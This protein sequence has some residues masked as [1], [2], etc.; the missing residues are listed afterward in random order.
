MK[1][2]VIGIFLFILLTNSLSAQTMIDGLWDSYRF[3]K[4][5]EG[6]FPEY[7]LKMSEIKGTPYLDE[8]YKPG[9]IV[10]NEGTIYTDIPLRYNAYSDDLE[11]QKDK[12]AYKIEPK[13]IIKSAEFGGAIFR[14]MQYVLNGK[15]QNGFFEILAEGKATLLMRYSKRF[16]DSEEAKAYSEAKPARFEE[17][18]ITYF[19]TIDGTPAQL[20]TSKKSLPELFGDKKSEMESYI[21]KNKIAIKG[22]DLTKIIVHFNSL[23]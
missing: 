17:A 14:C 8:A 6:I 15:T 13:T 18:K 9:K 1:L 21:S 23:Y 16:F 3:T 12:D 2:T 4:T 11:F 5:R 22:D 7:N 10:T 20:I 19:I